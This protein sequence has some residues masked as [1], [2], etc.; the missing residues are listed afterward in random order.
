[1]DDC[2]FCKMA[3]RKITPKEIIYED[4]VVF[5]IDDI[6]PQ[7]PIHVL[8]IPKHHHENIL[9]SIDRDTLEALHRA[10]LEVVKIKGL[11][12]GGFR[13]VANT[14]NDA[15]QTVNHLHLH[16]LGGEPLS[17]NMC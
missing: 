9:D 8:L 12:D 16:I 6:A 3:S 5:A 10:I 13:I 2:L 7:A 1:M 11:R 15:G 14:G 4:D 17:E